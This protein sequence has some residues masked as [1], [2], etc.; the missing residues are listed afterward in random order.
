MNSKPES[1]S[2]QNFFHLFTVP[3]SVYLSD[4]VLS[5]CQSIF[6][7]RENASRTIKVEQPQGVRRVA[8]Q[9]NK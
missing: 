4:L 1:A 2:H 7:N 9:Q 3:V 6:F 8:K 5:T